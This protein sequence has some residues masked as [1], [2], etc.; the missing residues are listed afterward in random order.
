MQIWW[1]LLNSILSEYPEESI[2]YFKISFINSHSILTWNYANLHYEI[3]PRRTCIL[4]SH[5]YR[6]DEIFLFLGPNNYLDLIY[7]EEVS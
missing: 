4:Y 7:G 3:P 5:A 6:S 2:E 1:L